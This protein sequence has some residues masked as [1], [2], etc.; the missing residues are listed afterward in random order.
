MDFGGGWVLSIGDGAHPPIDL[1]VD[2]GG[3]NR[4]RHSKGKGDGIAKNELATFEQCQTTQGKKKGLV[5]LNLKVSTDVVELWNELTN[6]LG[7]FNSPAIAN[8]TLVRRNKESLTKGSRLVEQAI[9]CNVGQVSK[10]LRL[11]SPSLIPLNVFGYPWCCVELFNIF[12]V[13]VRVSKVYEEEY[14]PRS[15]LVYMSKFFQ[16]FD[17]FS[18]SL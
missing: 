9:S 8:V 2:N 18:I 3:E 13:L 11:R 12:V 6:G 17:Q 14:C 15:H 10:I 1:S 7:S 16:N 4:E 5:T